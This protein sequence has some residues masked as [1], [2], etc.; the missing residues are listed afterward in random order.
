MNKIIFILSIFLISP[1]ALAERSVFEKDGIITAVGLSDKDNEILAREDACNNAKRELIGY[2]FGLGFQVNQNMVRTLGALDYSQGVEVSSGEIVIRGASPEIELSRGTTKCTL[3]YPVTEANLERERLK[4]AS[5]FKQTQ[6]TDVG[7]VNQ[8]SG[9]VLEIKTIPSDADVF[10]DNQRW[11]TT[12]IRLNGKLKAGLHIIRIE[13][14]NY[15]SVEITKEI[16]SSGKVQIE[17]ILKRA[18]GKLRIVTEPIDGATIMI[19]GQR[20]GQSPTNELEIISGQRAKIEANHPEAESASQSISLGRDEERTVTI[21]L[22]F[23]PSA[24]SVHVKPSGA[25]VRL[26]E[27]RTVPTDQ[28][29]SASAGS[30]RIVVTKDGF[31]EY[32]ASF[33]LRGGEKKTLSSIELRSISKEKERH[34]KN[35]PAWSFGL[36][37]G[38]SQSPLSDVDPQLTQLGLQTRYQFSR[39]FSSELMATYTTGKADYSDATLNVTGYQVMLGF[40]I[41]IYQF[42]SGL[43][44]LDRLSI[45]PQAAWS[46]QTYSA[47]YKTGG[48]SASPSYSQMGYGGSL[49]YSSYSKAQYNEK[50][51]YL[52][53]RLSAIKFQDAKLIQGTMPLSLGITW[54]WAW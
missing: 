16:P 43:I 4:S 40:P 39:L 13:H 17:E 31:E 12:P 25:L 47:S 52:E 50:G 7:D 5:S 38:V 23:K 24:F 9:G 10:V 22:Q 37:F 19:D 2:A 42:S 51:H 41:R 21:Q 30:H 26:D 32:T 33:D 6:F 45:A 53:F 49:I 54:G 3:T 15:K 14:E 20:I 11:G 35:G 8:V 46:N 36:Y 1:L 18:T 28:W 48:S 44:G 34:L 29:V 27:E